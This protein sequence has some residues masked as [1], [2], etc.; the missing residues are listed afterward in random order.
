MFIEARRQEMKDGS[1]TERKYLS[2]KKPQQCY[3]VSR[4]F[5]KS[6]RRDYRNKEMEGLQ[7]LTLASI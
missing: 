3:A 4:S 6:K 7:S 5:F 2:D 1:G